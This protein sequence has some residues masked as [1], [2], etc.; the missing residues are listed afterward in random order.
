LPWPVLTGLAAFLLALAAW[1]SG[2]VRDTARE[3]AF[4]RV[5]PWLFH[6]APPTSQV[7]IVDIDR[8][9]LARFGAWP[10]PRRQLASVVAAAA[11][12]KPAVIALDMLLA[13]AD[14]WS[15]DG[16]ALLA[17]AL[18][19]APS[20][21]GFVLETAK[22]TL[23]LPVTPILA[24]H[25]V[26]LPG[27]WRA[28]GIAGPPP[29]LA[30]AAVG[31]AAL[32]MAADPD[33]PI[34]RVP[35]LVMADG[36]TRPGLAVEA[37]LTAREGGT[38]VIEDDRTLRI[39][40][41][42]IPL[43]TD[44]LLRLPGPPEDWTDRTIPAAI[45]V[46]DPAVRASLA[47]KIV[48]IGSSAPE[49]GGLRVS[50]AS[51][52]TPSVW[53]QAEAI[54]TILRGTVAIRPYWVLTAELAA[55]LLLG[56]I[57]LSLA[58][59]MRPSIA[60]VLMLAI[61]LGWGGGA[62][63]AVSGLGLL[64]DPAG[65]PALALTGF[66]VA[67]V[68]RH[69]SD[70]WRARMLRLSFEQHLA[71]EVV[72]RIA[73]DPGALRLRGEMREI[74]ALFTDIEGFTSMTER[75][76]P[77]DLVALLDAY[78]E[79]TTRVITDQGGMID[80]IVGDAIHAIFNAPFSLEN[81]PAR[82]VASALALLDVSE[83]MRATPLG[84]QLRL[85]RTRIGIET[86]PAIVGDVGGGRKLDYTAHG[87]AMN[88]A[89]RLEAANKDF[90]SSICIGPGT[91]ARLDPGSLRPIGTLMPRGQ[92]REVTVYTPARTP[93]PPLGAETGE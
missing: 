23:D 86:G 66:I 84:R 67:V 57:G 50:A 25:A 39:A 65:P 51:P 82:A 76:E 22:V 36:I 80:K 62:F 63:V 27:V 15:T 40:G 5:L 14:R 58:A 61:C 73:A 21:L 74:T 52:A 41:L 33:G 20:V 79:A 37:I 83:T 89:A 42:T 59:R 9:A 4:D 44:G 91:A 16:D 18:G 78:F 72:R 54:A 64:I 29:S 19:V 87:N 6:R 69:A 35:L 32:A 34:R 70:E 30:D 77:T 31:F 75:A 7:V 71:P 1:A 49:L 46:D 17:R 38:L 48:L 47:G 11:E 12:G 2:S 28:A 56:A 3:R 68:T 53:L 55:A 92:S 8:A 60:A 90:G 45:L 43:G 93:S 85:G 13:G 10:W 24:R 88:A 26:S 81:H